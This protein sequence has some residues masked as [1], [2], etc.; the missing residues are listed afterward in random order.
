MSGDQ[1]LAALRGAGLVDEAGAIRLARSAADR[2]LPLEDVIAKESGIDDGAIADAKAAALRVPRYPVPEK[3][4][5]AAALSL[6]PEETARTY[7]VVPLS[8]SEGNLVVGMVN[9]DDLRAQEALKFLARQHRLNLGVFLVSAGDW[10]RAMRGYS[11]FQDDITEAVHAYRSK[12]GTAGAGEQKVADLESVSGSEDAPIIRVVARTLKEAIQGGASDVHIEPEEKGLRIRFRVDGEL[13]EAA[14]LPK[15]I[16]DQVIARVKVLSELKIDERRVPQDGRFRSKLLGK[17]IDFRVATFPTPLGEKVALRILD[18][19]TGLRTFQELGLDGKN[20]AAVEEALAE[21]YGMIL[22]TGPTGSGKTT[23]LYAALARINTEK[24]NIVSLEDPVEYFVEGVNQS[25]VRPE[26]G[27][28]F[29]AGLR[30]ILRQDPDVIMVGEIRDRE[31]ADL[32]VNAALTGHVVLSTL[33]TNDAAGVIP[34]LIDMGVEPFLLPA[35]LNLMVAQRLVGR[36]CQ[37][38]KAQEDASPAMAAEID[39]IVATLPADIA[40]P[41]TPYRLWRAPGCDACRGRGTAGRVA[42]YEVIKMSREIERIVAAGAS[43]SAIRDQARAQ[44]TVTMRQDGLLKALDGQVLLEEVL[45]ETN[46]E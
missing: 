28:D 22:V 13:H 46:E 6:V 17:E 12:T 23:S 9:P 30:Q 24:V 35:A 3:L 21:P 27:Y 26:I 10:Q 19:S 14:V 2:G 25:Q 31:T 32:A 44:G 41:A 38:C 7:Q 45:K 39:R 16:S 11:P 20:L 18:P 34:R 33:H 15:E 29:A 43:A 36:L 37:S 42:L 5:N 8:S 1:L 4:D 40:R